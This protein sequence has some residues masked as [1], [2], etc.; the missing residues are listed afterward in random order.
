MATG[1]N[2]YFHDFAVSKNAVL[3]IEKDTRDLYFWGTASGGI[4]L[5]SAVLSNT[6]YGT[7]IGSKAISGPRLWKNMG[8]KDDQY[9]EPTKIQTRLSDPT[10]NW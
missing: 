9:W 8:W 2:L 10:L 1:S 4:A 3:A 6:Y 7:E 5:W